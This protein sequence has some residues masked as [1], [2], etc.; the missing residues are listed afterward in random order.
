MPAC[1]GTADGRDKTG[2]SQAASGGARSVNI[3]VSRVRE[4][5]KFI[6]IKMRVDRIKA[7]RVW[8]VMYPFREV[9]FIVQ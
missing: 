9:Y 8:S 7:R 2:T 3:W 6:L 5:E 1:N 4:K